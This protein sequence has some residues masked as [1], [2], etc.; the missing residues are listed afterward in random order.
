MD[1]FFSLHFSGQIPK[2]RNL[3]I[4]GRGFP[5]RC[6]QRPLAILCDSC[7]GILVR[8]SMRWRRGA[9]SPSAK[10]G[11][12]RQAPRSAPLTNDEQIWG[13]VLAREATR[14]SG[15]AGRAWSRRL[16]LLFQQ[17]AGCSRDSEARDE[18]VWSRVAKLVQGRGRRA[19]AQV[20]NAIKTD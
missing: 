2:I 15:K 16:L 8:C 13:R 17:N 14:L 5:I 9:L 10:H 18:G 7:P 1:F 12:P 11:C 6:P 20:A 3:I 4:V 19:R